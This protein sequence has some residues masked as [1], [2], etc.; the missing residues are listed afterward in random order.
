MTGLVLAKDLM[1]SPVKSLAFDTG[2]GDAA[3]LLNRWKVSGAPVLDA[4]GRPLGVFT[5][6]D[7]ARYVQ[8]RLAEF[9][10]LHPGRGRE[11]E[12]RGEVPEGEAFP[13]EE[14]RRTPVTE[15]MTLGIAG[16]FPESTFEE[17]ARSMCSLGIHRVFVTTE[18]GRLVGVITTLDVLKWIDR[19]F[20]A[21]KAARRKQAV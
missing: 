8:D 16:V 18:E 1:T 7:L 6:R 15:F 20:R 19:G 4:E 17:V 5:L 3:G 12:T 10:A 14:F 13:S 21:R 11:L 2:V 9:P